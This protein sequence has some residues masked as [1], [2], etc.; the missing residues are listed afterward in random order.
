M[1]TVN[2]AY[3]D[4]MQPAA[5][6][7]GQELAPAGKELGHLA[8]QLLT[9]ICSVVWRVRDV[10]KDI[11]GY[12][13]TRKMPNVPP[14]ERIEPKLGFA[15]EILKNASLAVI[16]GNK[17]ARELYANLLAE[18]MD[19]RTASNAH[20]SYIP[21]IQQLTSDEAKVMRLFNDNGYKPLL[22][23]NL[24]DHPGD[25]GVRCLYR[26]LSLFSEQNLP[27]CELK[28]NMP[29][30]LENLQRLGLIHL[31]DD[32]YI[33]DA[34]N[35]AVLEQCPTVLNFRALYEKGEAKVELHR[36]LMVRTDFGRRFYET[37]V[38]D[39]ERKVF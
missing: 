11:Y 37:C 36:G 23:I 21:I 16:D 7:F 28:E 29:A 18:S 38:C 3:K 19:R 5:R 26:H 13:V 20:P 4:A 25:E 33:T 39:H 10:A 34:R 24:R 14:E 32:E 22:N 15:L 12:V 31:K 30:Y 27:Q 1:S 35:Y 2:D 9:D 17:D 8:N 6:N